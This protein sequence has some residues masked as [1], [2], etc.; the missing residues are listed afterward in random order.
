MQGLLV[1]CGAN[2]L[3]QAKMPGITPA[4]LLHQQRKDPRGGTR[5]QRLNPIMKTYENQI[6]LF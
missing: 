6:S 3:I 1:K 5:K 4:L 2:A